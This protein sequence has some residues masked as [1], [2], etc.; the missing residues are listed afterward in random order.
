MLVASLLP[1][2]AWAAPP[3]DRTGVSLPGLQQDLKAKLDKVEAAKLLGWDGAAAAPPAGYEPSK[4]APPA[5]GSEPVALTPDSGTQLVKAGAL[6][7]SIGKASPSESNPTPPAPSGTWQ[8][9]VEARTAT[10][11][12]GIDGAI[13]KVTPPTGSATPVDVQL[14]YKKFEDLYGTEWASRLEIK[15]LPE[16]FLTSPELPECSAAVDVPSSNDPNTG[17]VRATVDPTVAVSGQGLRTM[18]GGG[19]MVLAASDGATGAGGSYKATSLSPSGSWSAGGSG[20]GF[21][22]AYPLTVPPSPAGPQPTIAFSYSSQAV[23]GKTSVANGQGSWIGDGWGYEPGYIERRYRACSEDRDTTAATPNNNNSTDKKKGDLCWAGDN[24]VMSLGGA[25]TELVRDTVSGQLVPASDDGSKVERVTGGANGAKDGEYWVVTT[26]D[27]T[28]YHFGRHN[29]GTHGV[30]TSPQNVT[31]SVFTVPVFGNHPGEPCYQAAYANSSCRQAWRWNLDYVEDVHGN[32]MVIDWKQEQNR[33]AKNAKFKEKNAAEVGY[34]RGGYPTRILYGLRSDNLAGAPA[35]LVEFTLAER[36]LEEG[37]I[38][39]GDAQFESKNYGD[40]QA[41]WDTPST[42]NCKMDAENCYVS[43]PTFWSRKRLTGVTTYAQRTEGSTALST[44]DQWSLAQSFPKQRTDTHPPLW[45]ESITRTGYGTAKDSAG[46]PIGIQ[47]PPV[48]F[49]PNVQDMP[50]RVAKSSTDATPDYDRLRVETIRNE[51]GGEIYVDYSAPCAVG[52]SHPK[53]EENTTRCFPVHWSPDSELETPP[54]EWFNKYVVDKVIEKD[55]VARQPDVTTSYTYEGDAAWGKDTDEFSKPERRTY[56]QWRGYASVVTT[57]GV[58]A[59]AGKPDATE[60]SQTRTRYFRGMSGDG[61]RAKVRIKDSTNTEDLGEDILPLQGQAAETISFTKAG[62]S[63]VSRVLNWP[64][65]QRTASRPRRGTTDLEAF[66]TGTARSDAHQSTSDG[67]TRMVRTVNTYDEAAY[68]L[69][70]TAQA[71]VLTPNGTGWTTSEQNCTTTTYVH[72]T[73]KHIIGLAQ[74]VRSTAG[75]CGKAATGE[76]L[77]DARTSYDAL[78]A[79]GTAPVRGLPVQVDS[80]DGAGTGWVTTTRTEYDALGRPTKSYDAAGNPTSTTVSPATGP[81]FSTTIT[82]ALGHT[83]TTKSDPGRGSVLESTDANGRKVSMAYDE[84]GRT[85]GVWTPSRK[86]GTDKA[87]YVFS[88]DTSVD[89]PPTVISGALRDNGTYENTVTIYDGLLRPRQTQRE[90]FGGGRLVTDSLHNANGTVRQTNNAYYAE[91]EPD[92]KIFVPETVFQVPNATATAYDGLGRPV[93]STT[94][95]KGTPHHSDVT[96]Y[97]GDWTVQRSG[98]SA[99]GSAPMPGSEATKTW[100]DALNRTVLV[101]KYTAVDLTTWTTTGYAYDVRGKL[102]KVTDAAANNWTYTYDARGRLTGTSDPDLGIGSFGYNNLDQR[103]WAENAAGQKTY[104]NYDKLGRKTAEIEDDPNGTPT[105]TWTF[106]TLSGAKGYPVASTRRNGSLTVTSQ[107]TGYDAE[108]R[109]TGNTVTIPDGPAT[110]GLAGTYAYTTKYTPTGKIQ[111]TTVPATPGGLA[112]EKL[113]TRYNEDGAPVTLSG[114]SWYTADTV[115]SPFGEVL[116]TASGNAPQRVWTTTL[117]EPETGRVT[118]TFADR[119][120]PGPNRI[121]AVSYKYDTVGRITSVTDTQP[122]DRVD[123]Q[124]YAYNALGQL[125]KAWTGRT[126]NC[127][128]PSLSDVTAGPDGDGYWQEY[129]FDAIGNRTKLVDRD[130]TSGALDDSTT[131]AYG[132]DVAAGGQPPV[133]THPH[134]L[135]EVKKTT[136]TPNSTVTSL[137]TYGYDSAGNT[138]RRTI[139]GD[140]QTLNWDRRNKPTSA[141]SPGVGAVAVTGMAGKCLDVADGATADGTAVQILPCNETKAQQ[142]KLTGDTVQALG[143]CLTAQGA[144]AVLATCD[145]GTKQKFQSRADKTLYNP[146]SNTCVTVPNDNP[147]DG[148]DLDM[149]TCV[150]GAAAQQW[151]LADN[152]TTYVYGPDGS[153][154]IQETGSARTL[155]LGEA[156]V[157]VNKA[158]QAVDAIRYYTGPGGVTTTRQTGGK[159]T[160]HKLTVLLSDN[161]N[162]ATTAVEQKPGQAVTRRKYDP[163][164]NQRGALA[165]NWPGSRTFLG[166]GNNDAATGLTHIG[167]REYEP[168]NGR[169][170]SVDPVIDITNPMQMNGYVYANGDPVNQ[171][172]PTGLES[173]YPNYCAG[174]NGTYGDYKPENDPE[175]ER[176]KSS[177]GSGSKGGSTGGGGK[178]STVKLVIAGKTLP[179]EEEL[180][181]RG[182]WPTRTYQENLRRWADGYC[183]SMYDQA[184]SFCDTANRIGLTSPSGD[185]MEALGIRNAWECAKNPGWNKNCGMAAVDITITIA[186]G[187]IGRAAKAGKAAKAGAGGLSAH[188][189]VDVAISCLRRNSFTEETLVLM[190]DGTSKKIEEIAVGDKVLAT[191]PETGETASKTVTAEIRT[192]DDKKY[193]DLTVGSEDADQVITTTDHHPFWSVSAGAWVDAADLKVGMTLRTDD[194]SAVSVVR[195][196]TYRAE[197]PTYNLTVSD[198]H[199]YYVLAGKMPVLVHNTTPCPPGVPD[200]WHP[201]SFETSEASFEWHYTERHGA[202]AG[203]T[204]E[205]YLKDASDWAARLAQPGGKIGLDAKRMPMDGGKFGVKYVDKSTGMGGILG[206]DGRVVSFWYTAER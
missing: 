155:Y 98:M 41:W 127:T 18:T 117:Y 173:C 169:F 206:P 198:L 12:A 10:E 68:G 15:Q 13:I 75:D 73:A 175:V 167:A 164:G 116:R 84:L 132:V 43:S 129:E 97:G 22:W 159:N 77:A 78:G 64:W 62:G 59:N 50:N 105:A 140:T 45:L 27:G 94:L 125:A 135:T 124:C 85:T 120:T 136:K 184:T 199:T 138:A 52:A 34:T 40:K 57:K 154:L 86:A 112:A 99:D 179:T 118:N 36:C 150:A 139:D 162:T 69:L 48:S 37:G 80:L 190:A 58:T 142:W 177:G 188:E 170:I 130:L 163:Y 8:V 54:L 46:N 181:R 160:G 51:T 47:L 143:K 72:N 90:A 88:Y 119:E 61:G 110:K 5:A 33:Y 133:K 92:Q 115:L 29:V 71:E 137:S 91:G 203:V 104:T 114:L 171:M 24:L 111:S 38:K 42:L 67:G 157:T 148:N 123:R 74:R 149:Y 53:P 101:Q 7:I 102:A 189:A 166:T 185:W 89:K 63:V 16:C 122:G 146:A 2:Q 176:K 152:T 183:F 168:A 192:E 4:V 93:R 55:R 82:N 87:T 200:S 178:P 158:G 204:R 25:T 109:A 113:I 100:T 3:G 103:V 153:R 66:R 201:G 96:T 81:V 70:K 35:G 32:A 106:D 28:R 26:R 65:S 128:G 9:A 83:L 141:S 79:F 131:Y 6:P 49:L 202:R 30:G 134:A 194:G 147:V 193:V 76:V 1:T 44:V 108:Y 205:Q 165:A 17:T 180:L 196:R 144:D 182:Y 21:S 31:D 197:Q 56:S 14:D 126:E 174:S 172:D 121:N 19:S 60:Q 23:D 186:T 187:A 191:D 39:C 11:A 195:T 156:E 95:H 151:T 20:G 161:H 145:G 107:V